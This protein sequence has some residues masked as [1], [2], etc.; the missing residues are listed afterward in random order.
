MASRHDDSNNVHNVVGAI[1]FIAYVLAALFLTSLILFSLYNA[2][3]AQS[4]LSSKE[5]RRTSQQLQV[6]VALAVLSFSTLSYHM[7]SYLI[8]SYRSWSMSK[9]LKPLQGLQSSMAFSGITILEFTARIWQWLTQ[10]TLFQDF[11]KTICTGS[12]NFWWTQQALLATI[13]AA[14]FISIEGSRRQ[15][16]LIW[17]YLAIGQILPISFAQCLFFIAMILMPVPEPSRKMQV[18]SVLVQCLPLAAYYIS[19]LSAPFSVGKPGFIP[20]IVIIRVLLVCPFIFRLPTLRSLSPSTI[21]ARSLHAGYSAS[22]KMALFCSLVLFVQQTGLAVKEH[23]IHQVLAAVN[24]NPAVSA[25][26]YDFVLHAVVTCAWLT[27]NSHLVDV[28]AQTTP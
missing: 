28:S 26:G 12:A 27:Y 14:L 10:S 22:Y 1:I 23:G 20:I 24:S 11:A 2:Y 3:Q 4:S 8:F 21:P 18:P 19:V 16:P 13:V 9:N 15:V 17:A 25:L 5:A 7:L 6:F